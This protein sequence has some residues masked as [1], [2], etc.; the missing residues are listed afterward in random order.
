MLRV[1]LTGG[2][3]SGKSTVDRLFAELGAVIV[4]SDLIAREVVAP[5]TEGLAEIVAAFGQGILLAD[6]GL[7]RPALG[8]IVF[9]DQAAR[10][11]LEGITHPRI[12]EESARLVRVAQE[13]GAPVLIHDIPLLVESGIAD[14]FDAVVLVEAPDDVRLQRL[15]G[16]GLARAQALDRMKAQASNAQRRT[17]LV[18]VRAYVIDNGSTLDGLRAQVDE[19]WAA[20]AG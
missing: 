6:G 11:V 2:I 4:D 16:R 15:E 9:A 10:K 17:A 3:G 8:A 5:G 14:T 20:L 7:D 12:Q 13:S 1:G 18:G 19:V